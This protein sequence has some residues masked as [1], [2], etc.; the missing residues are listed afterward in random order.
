MEFKVATI[1]LAI[2]ALLPIPVITTRPFDWKIYRTQA[3][4]SLSM[5]FIRFSIALDSFNSTSRAMVLIFFA[6]FN[7]LSKL[8][9][10]EGK[11]NNSGYTKD[12]N[13]DGA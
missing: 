5:K 1:L 10:Q 4:K 11:Y 2:I 6:T 7:S 8:G 9:L 3:S 13:Y 12:L